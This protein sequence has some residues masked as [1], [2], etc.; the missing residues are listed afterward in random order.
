MRM[1]RAHEVAVQLPQHILVGGASA[2]AGVQ[3]NIF[4]AFAIVMSVRVNGWRVP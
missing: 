2:G 1:I 3:A 4:D